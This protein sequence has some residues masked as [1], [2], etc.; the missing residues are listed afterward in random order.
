MVPLE[1]RGSRLAVT[2]LQQPGIVSEYGEE[3][4][5]NIGATFRVFTKHSL[6]VVCPIGETPQGCST[7]LETISSL[8]FSSKLE[9]TG[10]AILEGE[11]VFKST[12]PYPVFPGSQVSPGA[13]AQEEDTTQQINLE[14]TRK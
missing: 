6:D 9:S 3:L 11:P 14:S 13:A 4:S 7:E 10:L 1:L 2:E 8:L 12:Q 5:A